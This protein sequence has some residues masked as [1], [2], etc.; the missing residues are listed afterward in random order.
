MKPGYS[1]VLQAPNPL[2]LLMRASRP[3]AAAGLPCLQGISVPWEE[4]NSS[5]GAETAK[6][7]AAVSLPAGNIRRVSC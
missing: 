3:P 6:I 7:W 5:F 2:R 4:Q 1:A